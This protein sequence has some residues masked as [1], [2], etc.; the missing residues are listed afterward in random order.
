[1][2]N[3]KYIVGNWKMNGMRA[4]LPQIEAIAS[5][6]AGIAAVDVAI[7]CPATLIA[8]AKAAVS[9]FP[10]G[11]QDCHGNASGA[12]TGCLSA[13]MLAEAGAGFCIVGHSERRTDQGESD[14]DVKAKA[15]AANRAGMGAIVCVGE[16]E[17]ERDA[18]RAVEVVTGQ[19]SGSFP[20]GA[21][22]DW[23]TIA[24]EPVWAIGTG[25]VPEV[26]DVAEMHDAIRARLTELMGDAGAQV[27]I[28]YGGS[29]KGSNA[30]EL[31]AIA[32][33]DGGLVGGASLTADAFIPIIDAAAAF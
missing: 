27:R 14:T 7:A 31:L 19:L 18:G 26:A 6:A 24:Y 10:I 13:E 28:L 1:M 5:H 22:P 21:S 11:A 9:D 4:D 32:N 8:P 2:A 23:L 20:E 16:T 3:R 33:V 17:A 25:R 15:A 12:H 29:M 30:A